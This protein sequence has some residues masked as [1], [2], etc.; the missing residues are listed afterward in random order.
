L[1]KEAFLKPASVFDWKETLSGVES[2]GLQQTANIKVLL[3]S[4][5]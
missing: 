2:K 4:F 1:S 3:T 5:I